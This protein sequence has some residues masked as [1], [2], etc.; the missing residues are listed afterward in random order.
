[1]R[2]GQRRAKTA[3]TG[4]GVGRGQRGADGPTGVLRGRI[5]DGR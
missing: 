5:D 3:W 2:H 4:L 1:V